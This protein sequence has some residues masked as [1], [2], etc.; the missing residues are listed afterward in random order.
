[1]NLA[2]IS[3]LS[4]YP[5]CTCP[6]CKKDALE[7]R[8]NKYIWYYIHND[9]SLFNM[10]NNMIEGNIADICRFDVR[11]KWKLPNY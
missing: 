7:V 2:M 6:V 5:I 9:E 10:L 4:G 1:M 8:L 3:D 11:K